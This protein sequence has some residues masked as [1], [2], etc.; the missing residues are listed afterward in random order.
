MK[1]KT[2][3][4][5]L[6]ALFVCL[7]AGMVQAD[8]TTIGTAI[9]SGNEYNLI[10]EDDSIDGGLVWLDY[11]RSLAIWDSQVHWSLS[12]GGSL[13][14]NLNPGVTTDIDWSTGWRLPYTQDPVGGNDYVPGSEMGHL[15]YISLAN[16]AYLDNT[17]DFNNLTGLDYWSMNTS[18]LY[19]AW[20]FRMGDGN[21]YTRN[22]NIQYSGI[23]VHAGEVSISVVPEPISSTLF[24]V[25]GATLGF[26]RYMRRKK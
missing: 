21:Q 25:G 26:R 14:V 22:P 8:L 20:A 6:V 4:G 13:T 3:V 1:N 19:E 18:G 10:Y 12:L 9:Y 16:T 15:Y 17:G 5:M 11:T 7:T 23:A 24:I 2:L